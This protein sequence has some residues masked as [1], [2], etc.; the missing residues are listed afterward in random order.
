MA[1]GLYPPGTKDEDEANTTLLPNDHIIVPVHST[2][3]QND[4]KA[5]EGFLFFTT[6]VKCDDGSLE[7]SERNSLYFFDT[8]HITE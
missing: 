8:L 2:D 3:P 4:G 7:P 1:L 6:G 5:F